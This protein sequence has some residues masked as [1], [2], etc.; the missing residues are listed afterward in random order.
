MP[1][2]DPYIV[3]S[4][5][6]FRLNRHLLAALFGIAVLL[7]DNYLIDGNFTMSI[8]QSTKLACSAT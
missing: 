7:E 3:H 5:S 6:R 2:R 8:A 4:G 1:T